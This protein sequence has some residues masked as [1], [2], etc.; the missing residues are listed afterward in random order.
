MYSIRKNKRHVSINLAHNNRKLSI[1]VKIIRD[2][3]GII[4]ISGNKYIN[5]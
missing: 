2:K 4:M 3:K 1:K 5:C